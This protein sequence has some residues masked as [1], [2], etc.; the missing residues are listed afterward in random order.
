V[1][2][3]LA[4]MIV[5]VQQ[6][7]QAF[8][9]QHP[10][11]DQLGKESLKWNLDL[12]QQT[13]EEARR[14]IAGLRPTALDDFGL[15][16]ALR[17]QAESLRSEGWEIAYNERLGDERIPATLETALYRIAQEA[18]TNV[19]KHA[20]TMRVNLSIGRLGREVRLRVREDRERVGISGM[21][22][23]RAVGGN[24]PGV[25]PARDGDPDRGARTVGTLRRGRSGWITT[26][27]RR[28]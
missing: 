10:P 8:A 11:D 25:E 7:L 18:L 24:V 26:Q 14:V 21:Q 1:H 2:D 6:H 20:D 12:I 27:C 9:R 22:E 16:A 23:D 3:G 5:A 28:V 4:Q 13:V 17:L 15:A 19:R